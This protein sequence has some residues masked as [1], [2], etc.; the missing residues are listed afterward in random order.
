MQSSS[1]HIRCICNI[2]CHWLRK[3][4]QVL[5]LT[6]AQN[7]LLQNTPT[8]ARN[9]PQVPD[10]GNIKDQVKPLDTVA[11]SDILGVQFRSVHAKYCA[12]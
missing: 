12:I 4:N 3:K 10:L 8:T 5:P 1:T 6:F 7:I 2:Y 9:M 11:H